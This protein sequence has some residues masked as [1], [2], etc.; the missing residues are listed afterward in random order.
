MGGPNE[1]RMDEHDQGASIKVLGT[2]PKR[3][4]QG[5]IPRKEDTVGASISD[6]INSWNVAAL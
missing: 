6:P 2:S 3:M 5:T 4:L 1:H